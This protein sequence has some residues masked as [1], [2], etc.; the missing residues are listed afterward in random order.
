MASPHT[1]A[2]WAAVAALGDDARALAT[3]V[4]TPRALVAALADRALHADAT[5]LLAHL[6]PRREAVWWALSCARAAAGPAPTAPI[7]ESLA[8]TERWILQPTDEHRR[9]AMA[10][11]E[12]ADLGSA[13]GMTGLAAFLS[14]GSIAPPEAP[15]TP[16]GEFLAAKA[17]AGAVVLATVA[18]AGSPDWHRAFLDQGVRVGQGVGLWPS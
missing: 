18:G 12:R 3:T 17:V 11:A 14:A 6:L 7:A 10:A 9:E 16:P 8:A 2:E 1:P 5:R 15:H 13:A 4:A